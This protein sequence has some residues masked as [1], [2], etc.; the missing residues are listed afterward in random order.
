MQSLQ[1]VTG[2]DAATR[3][4]TFL[5]SVS[6]H[7]MSLDLDPMLEAVAH[8]ALPLFGDLCVIDRSSGLSAV[9]LL[10]VRH[11]AEAR[12]EPPEELAACTRG[13]IRVDAGRSR[14]TVPIVVGG[15]R[16]GA[17]TF[18]GEVGVHGASELALAQELADRLAL[19]IANIR[20]HVQLREALVDREKLISIAAHEL[21][22]PICSVRLCIQALKRME[23][24]N[25]SKGGRLLE[26]MDREERRLARLID[27]L[28]DLTRLRSGQFEL[29]LEPVDLCDVVREVAARMT[30]DAGRAGS[31]LDVR[32]GAPLIGRWDRSRLDQVVTNLLTNAIK[33]GQKRP[34]SISAEVDPDGTSARLTV[35]DHGLGIEPEIQ[36]RIFEP[37]KRAVVGRRYEGL[38]L[39]LY[40]VR[41]IVGQL[42]GTVSVKSAPGRGATF[43]VELPLDTE[44]FE[45]ATG[46]S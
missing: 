32:V 20:T 7:L 36:Q 24:S 21:R 18:V 27:E 3:H 28:L 13:E 5:S 35:I 22:G 42:G 34:I 40:I 17:I 44:A 8:E 12:V 39:G 26:I 16:F 19:A 2:Q 6:R 23:R 4:E 9:R 14:L 1:E 41:N 38:G 29:D 45:R 37:F 31:E 33:F 25:A 11:G 30:M 43:T 10:E 46:T 15:E